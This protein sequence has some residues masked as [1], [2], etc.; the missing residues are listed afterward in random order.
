MLPTTSARQSSATAIEKRTLV[1]PLGLLGNA[2]DLAA[3]TTLA[4][5]QLGSSTQ[6][7]TIVSDGCAVRVKIQADTAPTVTGTTGTKI[8]SG[9]RLDVAVPIGAYVSVIRDSAATVNGAVNITEIV[10]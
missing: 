2:Y 5:Q 6:R 10:L 1:E 4:S 8:L 3:T 7:V 9:E